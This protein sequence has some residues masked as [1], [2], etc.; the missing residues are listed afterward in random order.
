MATN[1]PDK[2]RRGLIALIAVLG[3]LI[4]IAGAAVVALLVVRSRQTPAPPVAVS[5]VPTP[6]PVAAPAPAPKAAALARPKPEATSDR[7]T[8]Y[9]L[10]ALLGIDAKATIDPARERMRELFPTVTPFLL[11]LELRYEVPLAH[12]WFGTAELKWKNERAASLSAV[13][14]KPPEGQNKLANQKEIVECLTKGLGKP[15][16]RE[17]DHLAGEFSYFWGKRFPK[18]YAN[19]HPVNLWLDLS[20][21]GGA[22]PITLEHVVRTLDACPVL[23]R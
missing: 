14:F 1:D 11:A 4:M 8:R 9:P 17:V 12:A 21:P 16:V 13:G 23:P 3:F 15:E 2:L 10:R 7:V 5:P 6:K 22:A 20:E 19:L 18:A